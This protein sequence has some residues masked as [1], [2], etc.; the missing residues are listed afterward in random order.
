MGWMQKCYETYQNNIKHIGDMNE[1]EPLCPVAHMNATAQL[2]ILLDLDGNFLN[3]SVVEK[4]EGRILIPVTENS[5]GRGSGIAPH[6]LE[7]TLAYVAGDFHMYV[8]GNKEKNTAKK[9]F[10]AYLDGLQKW[11]GS[12]Y[13]C[14]KIQAIYQYVKKECMIGDLVQSGIVILENQVLSNNKI[15]GQNYEK[16]L[17]RFRIAGESGIPSGV[18]QDT[19]VIENY[20]DYYLETISG[21]RDYCYV[22]GKEEI[23]ANNHP[24]GI[25]AASYGA[26]LVSANDATGFTYRGR[27]INSQ[28]AYAVSYEVTQ[29]AHNALHWII[30]RQ[31]IMIGTKEKRTFACWNP[32]GKKVIN[33][34][35][36]PFEQE[37]EDSEIAY[38]N[39]EYQKKLYKC[40][41]G[42]GQMLNEQDDI[43]V[44]ALDAATTGRLS[45]TYYNELFSSDFYSRINEWYSS[46]VWYFPHFEGGKYKAEVRTPS[47][48]EIINYAFGNENKQAGGRGFNQMVINDKLLKEQVQRLICC[49]LNQQPFPQDIVHALFLKASAP[50]ANSYW[51][52]ERILSTACAAVLKRQHDLIRNSQSILV[53]KEDD[54]MTLDLNNKDRSYLFGRLLAIAEY[55]ENYAYVISAQEKRQTNAMKYQ[56]A[57]VHHPMKTWMILEDALKPYYRKF[58]DEYEFKKNIDSILEILRDEDEKYLNQPLNENY[59][60]GYYLQRIELYKKSKKDEKK[61]E[62]K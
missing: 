11:C 39:Q 45:V 18:W 9:K 59:L 24:K 7:D 25:V 50:Q 55:V 5:A 21:I 46:L 49:M 43:V 14:A 3:A 1:E 57:F 13:S 32:K 36:S 23:I 38:T 26:K 61:E 28:E 16:V 52:H 6:A 42:Y 40:L 62:E 53:K 35:K 41:M 30:A 19:R 44:I 60:L 22:T 37:E 54:K 33:I 29:K 27:F 4:G 51:V 8:A 47:M 12:V 31:G 34:F 56:T 2:E 20:S 15:A 48:Y 58:T 17:V 10:E